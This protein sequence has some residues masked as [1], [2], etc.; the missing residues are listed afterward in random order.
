MTDRDP[1]R[2]EMIHARFEKVV[3][4]DLQSIITVLPAYKQELLRL[5]R[6]GEKNVSKK[7]EIEMFNLWTPFKD[8]QLY[9]Q[10]ELILEPRKRH[11]LFGHN[12]CGKSTLFKAMASGAL[13]DQG[14][15][16]HISVLHM[17]EIE[18]S[19]DNGS[20]METVINSHELL[21]TLRKCRTTLEGLIEK[22]DKPE[23]KENLAWVNQELTFLKDDTAE[24]RVSKMLKPLGFD[25]KAQQKNVNDLSGGLR[26]RVA[27]VC[28]FFQSPD[29]LLLDEP[30]NHLDFPSVLW[31]ENRLRG[32]SGSFLL[33]THDRQLL[34]NVCNSV[35][36]IEEKEINYYKMDFKA[37]EKR[38]A[39]DDKKKYEEREKFISRNRNPDPSTPVGR[40]VAIY[41]AWI[42]DYTARQV[43][44]GDMFTFPDPSPLPGVAEDTPK[45]DIPLISMKDVTFGYPG[46]DVKIFKKPTSCTITAATRMGI[47]GPNGAGKSTFLKLLTGRLSPSTGTSTV[48][49]GFKLAYFG[50][51]SAEELDLEMTPFEW[52]C[53]KYP[54]VKQ[55]GKLKHH[56]KKAGMQGEMSDTR[57]KGFSGG[58]KAR[59]IFAQLTY[60]CPHLLIMDEPT[61]FLDL[62]SVDSLITAC[63]KY[64]GAM[65]L[66]THSRHMLHSCGNIYLSITPGKFQFFENIKDC[67]RA[68]YSFIKDVEEGAKV[69][70]SSVQGGASEQADGEE[71]EE[72]EFTMEAVMRRRQKHKE[73][74]AAA[75]K[76]KE[77]AKLKKKEEMKAKVVIAAQKDDWK[78]GDVA[79]AFWHEDR[80][81]Y[82]AKVRQVSKK[83]PI[84][85][86]V[87]FMQYGNSV[88]LDPAQLLVEGAE[89]TKELR[90]SAY[91]LHV[92][93]TKARKAALAAKK[94]K[95]KEDK[96][97][98]RRMRR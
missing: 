9:K 38:K 8:K 30:T 37:F 77:D 56:L 14:F 19:P 81:F 86:C 23:Y 21:Y 7:V 89:Q 96:M 46:A 68:T 48:T 11:A 31:L 91:Y 50:Q 47:M 29:L 20:L 87:T 83:K 67:E 3:W 94:Q 59:V 66:V 12:G 13:F 57:M 97:R 55:T 90:Q 35:M 98:A 76:A 85:V 58:Q 45:E 22:E 75:A 73:M 71:E 26:M 27:L 93:N 5:Q 49:E 88:V 74:L 25:A 42:K 78:V 40:R 82:K 39:L 6:E 72:E 60:Q 53:H 51:H 28:A 84:K 17:Q 16:K 70:I 2:L 34:E 41:K 18:T 54:E 43:A 10:T 36:L 95:A 63:N 80:K 32:Y 1:T 79:L 65:L 64:P 4:T 52:M 33:V 24:E 92:E 61:N 44:I 62:E 69:K 15:P